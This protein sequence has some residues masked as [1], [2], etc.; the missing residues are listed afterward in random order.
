[1]LNYLEVKLPLTLHIQ[2]VVEM[3]RPGVRYRV[4]ILVMAAKCLLYRLAH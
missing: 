2:N 1:M 3:A 4:F